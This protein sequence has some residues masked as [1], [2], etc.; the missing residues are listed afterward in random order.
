MLFK[1]KLFESIQSV[2]TFCLI[3]SKFTSLPGSLNFVMPYTL[4]LSNLS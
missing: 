1:L 2:K 4:G 3:V